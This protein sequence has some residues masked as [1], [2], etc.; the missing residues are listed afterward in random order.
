MLVYSTQDHLFRTEDGDLI[1]NEDGT[2]Y[3]SLAI[4]L[5][6][7]SLLIYEPTELGN[8]YPHLPVRFDTTLSHQQGHVNIII[9]KSFA[10]AKVNTPMRNEIHPRHI[11]IDVAVENNGSQ[12][13]YKINDLQNKTL[14][15]EEGFTYYFS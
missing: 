11:G 3:F 13:V 8:L 1:E 9:I 4:R 7:D 15:L 12:N 10:E 14:K 2:G 6:N 5:A